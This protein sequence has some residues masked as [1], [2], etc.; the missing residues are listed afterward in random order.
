MAFIEEHIDPA[1]AEAVY[2]VRMTDLL[3]HLTPEMILREIVRLVAEK[4][5]A[6][7]F[8]EIA[9]LISQDAIATMAVAECGAKIRET[10]EKKI[11]DK[12]LHTVTTEREVW[13]RGI[14]GGMTRIR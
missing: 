5:V 11:P 8:Q 10:L 6:E 1:R 4:Y 13:Q 7:H 3:N 12:V 14:L 9:A 2:A